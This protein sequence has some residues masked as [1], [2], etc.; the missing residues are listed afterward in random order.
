MKRITKCLGITGAALVSCA[1]AS[2]ALDYRKMKRTEGEL[3]SMPIYQLKNK[4]AQI[5]SHSD[6]TVIEVP[7]KMLFIDK[8][9]VCANILKSKKRG[10]DYGVETE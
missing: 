2:I 5:Q 4:F 1:A 8:I 3:A 6:K 7:D 9:R 10:D